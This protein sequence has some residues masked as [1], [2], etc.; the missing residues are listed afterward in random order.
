MINIKEKRGALP[1]LSTG[2]DPLI[3]G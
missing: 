1:D 2:S 3:P